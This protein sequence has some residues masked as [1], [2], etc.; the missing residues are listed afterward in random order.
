M[1]GIAA[2]IRKKFFKVKKHKKEYFERTNK[3]KF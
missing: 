3:G 2:C 1:D